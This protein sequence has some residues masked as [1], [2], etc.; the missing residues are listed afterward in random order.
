MRIG[1]IP[2]HSYP[3]HLSVDVVEDGAV[4]HHWDAL[5]C[6]AT[7][8]CTWVQR[9]VPITMSEIRRDGIPLGDVVLCLDL[10]MKDGDTIVAHNADFDIDMVLQCSTTRLQLYNNPHV[11]H[12]CDKSY[13]RA[14]LLYYETCLRKRRVREMA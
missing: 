14:T 10:L 11:R 13:V 6:G 2:L 3:I 4:V 12:A 8:L 1:P 9:N 7:Q 5:I